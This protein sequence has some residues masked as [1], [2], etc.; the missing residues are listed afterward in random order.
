MKFQKLAQVFWELEQTSSSLKMIDIL[1][2]F[3]S[4]I[5][6]E[7][8]R[9]A[10]NLLRGEIAPAYTGLELGLAEKLVT[11][12]IAKGVG[13]KVESVVKK[14]HQSGD[15]GSS[16]ELLKK[17]KK[18]SGLALSEVFEELNKIAKAGGEGSQELKINTL[19]D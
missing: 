17:D 16:V 9:I 3:F 13:V 19:A 14:F 11:R 7:D 5:R 1:A 6:A 12:A 8:A 15:L 4:E 10:A 2:D 18:G